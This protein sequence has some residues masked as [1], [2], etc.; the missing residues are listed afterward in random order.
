MK[1]QE[2]QA[3]NS[4]ELKDLFVAEALENQDQL[5]KLL[6][7]LE[8]D[9]QHKVGHQTIFRILHTL[10]A[11]SAAMGYNQ[12]SEMAH[13]LED[14]YV[15]IK[16]N[17]QFINAELFD[18]LHQA[19]DKLRTNIQGI[20]NN[21][22]LSYR[23]FLT[24]LQVILR[25]LKAELFE[26][27]EAEEPLSS[28]PQTETE[29][30][31]I[32]QETSAQPKSNHTNELAPTEISLADVIPISIK[33]LDN[34][35]NLVGE[36]AIEQDRIFDVSTI[37]QNSQNYELSNLKRVT[38]DLQYSIMSARLIPIKSLFQKFHR[39]IRDTANQ[40][41]KQV[42]LI[43]E[44]TEIEIDR[45][46]LQI[47]SDSLVHLVRNAVSH[48]I[49]D[50]T[51]RTQFRKSPVGKVTLRAR[52]DKDSVMIEVQDDG[53]G[54]D[55]E[56]IKQRAIEQGLLQPEMAHHLQEHEIIS[57]IFAPGFSSASQISE[58]S[59]RGIGMNVVK[60]AMDKVGGRIQ[61]NTQKQQGTTFQM[62]LPVSLALRS[63]ILFQFQE[64]IAAVPLTHLE[65]VISVSKQDLRVLRNN[66]VIIYMDAIV[67]LLFLEGLFTQ[68]SGFQTYTNQQECFQNLP[69][70]KKYTILIVS[71]ENRMVGLVIDELLQKKEIVEKKL[72]YPLSGNKLM[73]GAAILSDGKVCLVLNIPYLIQQSLNPIQKKK[74]GQLISNSQEKTNF[75]QLLSFLSHTLSNTLEG[76]LSIHQ[77]TLQI[78]T[79]TNPELSQIY[80]ANQSK[81]F[82]IKSQIEG[83]FFAENILLIDDES[84]Q[85]LWPPPHFNPG[86]SGKELQLAFLMETANILTASVVTKLSNQLQLQAYGG[87]PE[88]QEL[89]NQ[90]IHSKLSRQQENSLLLRMQWKN[91]GQNIYLQS[92]WYFEPSILKTI[93]ESFK[94]K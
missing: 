20:Q 54:I 71:S 13:V 24:R 78:H 2:N 45:N 83:D 88:L 31:T 77:A 8:K 48:G 30:P 47:I 93:Y 82:L 91:G 72:S 55:L 59:G 80:R 9:P 50:K 60:E 17:P 84:A 85:G 14:I 38:T 37:T 21:Q 87:V 26:E 76:W 51:T 11:N 36:L 18:V 41:G 43:L 56:L 39:I 46:I 67:P 16:K 53:Q 35:L 57:Y 52:N 65:K 66:L 19:N 74:N 28:N 32:P 49:E 64:T 70:D 6:I 40:E 58:I 79:Q 12:L 69:P 89:S 34:M 22:S 86:Q 33:K 3:M 62:V 4:E 61:I 44:G 7:D 92:I 10:K 15:E 23:G 25:N 94:Y 29:I 75:T 27:S 42:E 90:E 63:V 73:S 1:S 68:D 5:D 81:H